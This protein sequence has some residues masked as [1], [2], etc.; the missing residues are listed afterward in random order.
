MAILAGA[1]GRAAAPPGVDAELFRRAMLEDTYEVVAGLELVTPALTLPPGGRAEAESIVWPGTQLLRAGTA[2]QV[3]AELADLGAEEA[4]LVVP[5]VPDLPALLIGKLFRA[6]GGAPVA[7]CPAADGSLVAVAV[8]LPAPGWLDDL[9]LDAPDA[10]ARLRGA[11]PGAGLVRR[12]PGWHRLRTPADLH[13]LDPGLEG[14]DTTRTL[15]Q[16]VPLN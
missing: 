2:A 15:L 4:A 13:H 5:D 10:A 8:R 11:A 14:W 1:G 7:A 3:L 9:D 6:L 12:G 16:G